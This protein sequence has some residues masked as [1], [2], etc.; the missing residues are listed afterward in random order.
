[1]E[2]IAARFVK[3][4]TTTGIVTSCGKLLCESSGI[5]FSKYIRLTRISLSMPKSR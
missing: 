3:R 4:C 1:M 5:D 2:G